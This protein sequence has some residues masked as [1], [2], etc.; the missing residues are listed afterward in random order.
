M[1]IEPIAFG[2]IAK[3]NLFYAAHFSFSNIKGSSLSVDVVSFV[4]KGIS[5]NNK[6]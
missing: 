5:I 4:C 2:D 1:G 6:I 3:T